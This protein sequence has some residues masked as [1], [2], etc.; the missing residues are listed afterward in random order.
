MRDLDVRKN[1][2]I[3][4]YENTDLKWA[5]RASWMFR[6]FGAPRVSVLNG[7]FDKWLSEDLDLDSNQKNNEAFSRRGTR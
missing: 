5:C 3:V 6:A 7:N 1:D 4:L 2:T